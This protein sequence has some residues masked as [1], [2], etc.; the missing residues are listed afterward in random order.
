MSIQN[1]LQFLEGFA[2]I[3]LDRLKFLMINQIRNT[4]FGGLTDSR[5]LFGDLCDLSL[6]VL[7]IVI[8][9]YLVLTG[10]SYGFLTSLLSLLRQILSLKSL[11]FIYSILLSVLL[12]DPL[13]EIR[14][15]G[16]L[17]SIHL[18]LSNFR[19]KLYAGFIV[20]VLIPS[21]LRSSRCLTM[22]VSLVDQLGGIRLLMLTKISVSSSCRPI[23]IKRV[24]TI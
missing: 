8:E 11:S 13:L 2:F 16:L 6:M 24:D 9:S 18:R 23:V 22:C 5:I 15:S 17:G 3:I 7:L 10:I 12:K 19:I 1:S 4:L 14:K 21:P 20:G